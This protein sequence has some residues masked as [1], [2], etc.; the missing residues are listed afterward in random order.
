MPDNVHFLIDHATTAAPAA[1]EV[2]DRLQLPH[3]QALLATLSPLPAVQLP[4]EAFDTPLE[5]A[6]AQALGLPGG[7]GRIPWGAWHAA[8]AGLATGDAAWAVLTPCHLQVGMNEVAMTDPATI[9]LPA[10]QARAL[11]ASM[12]PYL[13]EDGIT[14]GPFA[15]GHWLAHGEPFRDLPT[16]SPERVLDED[17]KP[18]MPDSALL[19][20][21]QNEMQMLLYTHPVNHEREQAGLAPVNALWIHGCGALPAEAGRDRTLAPVV[22]ADLREPARQQDWRAWA[23]AWQQIDATHG[24]ALAAQQRAGRTV[25]ITLCGASRSQTFTATDRGALARLAA[26]WRRPRL[27]DLL[28]AA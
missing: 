19:R 1:R 13:A 3:L 2:L 25:Q 20:R 5:R 15:D 21:L 24:S 17:L 27:S 9:G 11:A 14:L 7:D 12:A 6:L 28:A 23:A 8:R 10:D 22:L 26:R 4:P 16:P 18:W